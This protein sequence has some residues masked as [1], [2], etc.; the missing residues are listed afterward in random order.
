MKGASEARAG[1][2]GP[3]SYLGGDSSN[4]PGGVKQKETTDHRRF[5]VGYLASFYLGSHKKGDGFGV[6]INYRSRGA[7]VGDRGPPKS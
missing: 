5:P 4:G 1:G 3:F 6:R 2:N 7:G